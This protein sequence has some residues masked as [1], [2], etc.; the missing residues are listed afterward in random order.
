MIRYLVKRAVSGLIA[1][2]IFATFLFFV[3][4]L[5]I[6]GDF[7][8]QLMIPAEEKAAL[9]RE[10]GL[11]L[12]LWQQYLIWLQSFVSGGFAS[13]FVASDALLRT[14]M[15]FVFGSGIAF[16]FGQWL[17]KVTAWRGRGI[18]SGAMT[19]GAI[20]FYTT[21]PPWLAFLVVQFL[22]WQ[23]GWSRTALDVRLWRTSPLSHQTVMAVMIVS[24]LTLAITLAIANRWLRRRHGRSLPLLLVLVLLAAGAIGVWF[25]FGFGPQALDILRVAVIPILTYAL[26]A[27]GEIT[28]VMQTTMRDTLNEDY[29][30]TARAKGLPDRVVRDRHAA[31]NA[32]LPVLNRLVTSLPYLLA[33]L[34]IIEATLGK[35]GRVVWFGT[36]SVLFGGLLA[37]N[38]TVVMQG[39]LQIGLVSLMA[40]L[41]LDVVQAY[42]DPRIRYATRSA[43]KRA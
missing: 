15:V 7:V 6:P 42:L 36:G 10:L 37:Q 5:L 21:F 25:A 43:E 38:M 4:Q 24:V 9:R 16:L 12:P 3:A 32:W 13:L 41:I 28:L 19:F 26:L 11:D 2:F 1:L 17:G 22:V 18:V 8:S 29:I 35:V 34:V 27:F 30:Q 20:A 40:R 23:I 31:R 14:L 39:I 33:G